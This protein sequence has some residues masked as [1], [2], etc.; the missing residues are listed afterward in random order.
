[1]KS[2]HLHRKSGNVFAAAIIAP[3][4]LVIEKPALT[5]ASSVVKRALNPLNSGKTVHKGCRKEKR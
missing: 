5:L 1:M 2:A 4:M 3:N